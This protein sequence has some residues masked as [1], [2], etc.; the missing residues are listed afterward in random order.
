MMLTHLA[1]TGDVSQH[2]EWNERVEAIHQ[3][4]AVAIE[5]DLELKFLLSR[6]LVWKRIR[7][8]GRFGAAA[9]LTL[10]VPW[11]LLLVPTYA[12]DHGF[13]WAAALTYL[14]PILPAWKLARK[15]F[16]RASLLGMRD[17]RANKNSLVKRM[18]SLP[19]S[20]MR[21]GIGGFAFGFTLLFLQGLISW[22]MTPLPTI[23]QE[24]YWDAAL[25]V[26][27]GLVTGSASGLLAPFLSRPP[28]DR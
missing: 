12:V 5:R 11:L 22:F 4:D 20:A 28:P 25:A 16:E 3:A 8:T 26:W 21:A 24:L 27:A 13:G 6:D 18:A 2:R 10:S 15:A 23:G 17:A 1:L 7:R 9:N 14:A 19:V